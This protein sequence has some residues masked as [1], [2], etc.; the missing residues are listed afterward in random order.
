M[1]GAHECREMSISEYTEED[2]L[3]FLK[4]ICEFNVDEEKI[5]GLW[6]DHFGKISQHPYRSD[7][8]YYPEKGGDQTPEGIIEVFKEWRAV[9][10]LEG[11]KASRPDVDIVKR[12]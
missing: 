12:C 5:L 9:N 10:G 4:D 7:L 6:L 3:V 8:I 1:R 2:F 11:F